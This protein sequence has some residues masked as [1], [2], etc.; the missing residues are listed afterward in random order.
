MDL[1]RT[2]A[3]TRFEEKKNFTISFLAISIRAFALE[4]K[5]LGTSKKSNQRRILLKTMSDELETR[6]T[7]GSDSEGSLCD[8]IAHD[9]DSEAE[10]ESVV[11][12]E[13]ENEGVGE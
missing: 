9:Y 4:R 10:E 3:G 7:D 8:F 11:S 1:G 6:S 13:E 12:E 2:T 5:F